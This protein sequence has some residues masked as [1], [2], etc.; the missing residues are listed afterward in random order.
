VVFCHDGDRGLWRLDLPPAGVAAES[1]PP[2]P[3]PLTPPPPLGEERAFADGRIDHR[4]HRWVGVM[5][6]QGRDQLVAVSLDGGEPQTLWEPVDFCGYAVLS[7][8]GSH[9]AWVEWQQPHMPWER[10]QLWLA[11]LHEAGTVAEARRVAGSGPGDG[12]GVSVFQP[13]WAGADLVVANDRSGWWNLERLVGAEALPPDGE[14]AW[15]PLLPMEAEFGQPQ[16]VYGLA[17]IAWDGER[18][19]ACA[20]REG[21]WQLGRVRPGAAEPWQPFALPFDDLETP[22]AAAGRLAAVAAGPRHGSGLLELEID[23]GSWQHTPA[24]A[25]V[26]LAAA[27]LS[28][29]EPLWFAGYAGRPTHAWFYPPVAGAGPPTPLLLRAHSGPTGMARTGLNPAIQFWTSR[30]WGVLD[31][32]YGG[33]SGFGRAYRERLDGQWGVV[34]VADCAAAARA[35]VAAGRAD[36]ERVAM[37]GGSAAGFTLL[38]ML[39]FSSVLRAGACRYAVADLEGMAQH[40]HRFEAHYLDTLVGPW[41]AAAA[42]YRERSPLLQAGRITAPVIF[43][44]GLED[45][46]VPPDQ[47]ERMALTLGERGIPVEVHL[48][49]GEGHG[50]R[51]RAVQQRVL[52]ATEA[53]F[54]RHL[55]LP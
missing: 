30:G 18:L 44:Q 40:T 45:A 13:L 24:A 36:G 9:L 43:F 3:R 32:N 14:V 4:R 20:C 49:P 10:S 35:V 31:V 6:R 34:D 55:N 7:P 26:A 5:E 2:E 50:F 46:V 38:A 33:S 25:P 16:W 53:F 52:E 23:T 15:E 37:E 39:C 21:R 22:V 1:P 54:R 17:T 28:V 48:F 8:S 29:P 12:R 41:P 47:T 51:N 42:T 11:R 27:A 19:L